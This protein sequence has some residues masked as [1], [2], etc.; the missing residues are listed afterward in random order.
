M[1]KI[2]QIFISHAAANSHVAQELSKAIESAS[3]S[4]KTFVASRPGDIRA[5]ENW[6]RE[7][8]RALK[9]ADAYVVL[10][11]PE[12]ILR[13]WVNF[14]SGAAW[15]SGRKLIFV[16]TQSLSIEE[17]PLPI[18]SRQIYL[19]DDAKQLYAVFQALKLSLTNVD[20]WIDQFMQATA[21]DMLIDSNEPAWE[22]IKVQ[23]VFYA[24]AGPLSHLQ[25]RD[26][27]PNPPGLIDKI[28]KYGLN[29]RWVTRDKLSRH[30]E[31]GLAQVF[32]TDQTTWRR[33]VM[34]SGNILMVG[35]PHIQ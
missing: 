18:K 34:N 32:A 1:E 22:G 28:K 2:M 21:K 16:R 11:T 30:T 31:R 19:L 4:V 17:I 25:D 27:A 14:E 23:D 29:P 26:Y 24:W 3:E 6:L 7:I 35:N 13:P 9:E 10:L 15:F 33:P 12:S 20:E 5:D 8:E